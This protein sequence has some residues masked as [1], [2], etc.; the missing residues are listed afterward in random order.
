MASLLLPLMN[1]LEIN[2]M[3]VNKKKRNL[4]YSDYAF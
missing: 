4:E 1:G 2:K 3:F